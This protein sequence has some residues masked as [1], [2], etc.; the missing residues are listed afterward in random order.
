[1]AAVLR[2]GRR[3]L[4]QTGDNPSVATL[5]VKD[6]IIVGGGITAKGGWPHAEVQALREAGA[7]AQGATAY[8]TMEPCAHHGKTPPCCDD[9]IKAGVVRVVIPAKD[10]NPLTA[11]KSIARLQAA[12]IEVVQGV[13][14]SEAARDHA[15]HSLRILE[16]RPFVQLKMAMTANRIVGRR[17]ERLIISGP[18]WLSYAQRLR[19]QADAILVGIGTVLADDPLLTCRLPGL[20]HRSPQRFVFNRKLRLPLESRLVQTAR[21]VPLVVFTSTVGAEKKAALED[22]GAQVKIIDASEADFIARA[23]SMMSDMGIARLLLEGGPVLTGA[24][25]ARDLVDQALFAQ[26]GEAYHGPDGIEAMNEEAWQRVTNS[27]AFAKTDEINFSKDQLS[28]YWRERPCLQ[29]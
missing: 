11:G 17:G 27:S 29:A 28:V 5:I 26:C 22:R 10:P 20:G 14:A 25:I 3:H 21:D 12:G 16:R 8:V 13:L 4:G 6:G 2:L 7:A 1:M 18:D 23:L 9:L 19:T 24:F 15:G